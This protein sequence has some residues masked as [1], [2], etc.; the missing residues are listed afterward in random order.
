MKYLLCLFIG[1]F[2]TIL[3][4]QVKV[5]K[6]KTVSSQWPEDSP[7]L[8]PDGQQL[9]FLRSQTR[10][11]PQQAYRSV[12]SIALTNVDQPV[13]VGIDSVYTVSFG[14]E[15]KSLFLSRRLVRQSGDEITLYEAKFT[16]GGWQLTN[17][18][19]RDG[20][21]AS[22]AHQVADGSLYLFQYDGSEGTGI[23]RAQ[24]NGQQFGKPIWQ[25]ATLSPPKTTSFSPYV[26]PDESAMLLTIYYEEDGEKGRT[27]IY[28]AQ[29]T[30]EGWKKHQIEGLPYGWGMNVD[31]QG[32]FLYYTDGEDILKV[33]LETLNIPFSCSVR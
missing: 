24:W 7:A 17:I 1:F 20:L 21:Q 18:T 33:E 2:T 13:V 16:R 9:M 8:S 23:Y 11:W 14:R 26:C 4:A 6:L 12:Y 27:G 10:E 22:Y 31:P 19:A 5:E 3:C 15:G 32:R 30:E 28:W 25:G 29:K